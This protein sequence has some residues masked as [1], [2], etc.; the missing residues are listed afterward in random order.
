MEEIETG[1]EEEMDVGEAVAEKKLLEEVGAE[2][3]EWLG[4]EL[5]IHT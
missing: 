2:E 3:E 1:E 4:K 5:M